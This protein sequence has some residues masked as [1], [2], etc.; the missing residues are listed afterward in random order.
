MN[1]KKSTKILIILIVVILITILLGGFAFA[2]LA[3]DIFRSEKDLF[4]KYITQIGD[5]ENGFID[6]QLKEYFEKRK[7]KPYNDEGKFSVNITAENRQEEFKNINNFNITYSGQVDGAN[8]KAEQNISI[9]YSDEV[10]FPVTYKQIGNTLGLQTKYI[11]SKYIAVETDN[12][13]NTIGED[14]T[15]PE[16][17][18]NNDEKANLTDEQKTNIKNTYMG[19]LNNNLGEEKFSKVK[20]SELNGYKLTLTGEELKNILVQLLETLK[21]DQTTLDIINQYLGVKEASN[22]LETDDIDDLIE[23]I[24]D[25]EFDEQ[26][27]EITVYSKNGKTNKIEIFTTNGSFYIERIK[28]DN[29]LKLLFYYKPIEGIKGK[30]NISA[31]FEGLDSM[32]NIKEIYESEIQFEQQPSILERASNARSANQVMYE[33][34]KIGLI[35]NESITESMINGGS[36]SSAITKES[37]DSVIENDNLYANIEIG[38]TSDGN[39]QIQFTDTGDIFVINNQGKIITKPEKSDNE[40]NNGIASSKLIQYNYQF[41]NNITFTDTVNIEELT[42]NNSMILT[43]YESEQVSNFLSAVGERLVQVNKQQMEELGLE[44]DENPIQYLIPSLAMLSMSGDFIGQT[45]LTEEEINTFNS[46]FE[47]YEGTNQQAQTVKGLL[48]TISRNNRDEEKDDIKITELNFNGQE[49]EATEENITSIK[50]NMNIEKNYRIEFE[51]DSDT[52]LIFRAVINE[53]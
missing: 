3:T 51:K 2:Y 31:T 53:K 40:E 32:Q 48:S 9:N 19:V 36:S 41:E 7:N 16:I 42:S 45:T 20:E 46:K 13:E 34:E 24:N 4:F 1:Q 50:N 33:E 6:N 47:N 37:L 52:G 14:I 30:F 29:K 27:I 44:E 38:N 23:S 25:E 35:V 12:L 8:S 21:N 10:N 22:K 43:D 28:E 26:N 11:G 15:V 49:Y 5:S 17:G 39:I 18:I